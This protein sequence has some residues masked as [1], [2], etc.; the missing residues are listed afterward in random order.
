MNLQGNIQ[1]VGVRRTAFATDNNKILIDETKPAYETK[2]L[3]EEVLL[4]SN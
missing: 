2:P 3:P 4:N 1:Q